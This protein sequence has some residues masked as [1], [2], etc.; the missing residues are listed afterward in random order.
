YMGV[1]ALPAL[2][3]RLEEHG[4]PADWPAAI[5]ERGTR[6]DQ[7]VLT[8]T[9]A[10]LPLQAASAGVGSPALII[11]GEVVRHRVISPA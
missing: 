4:L 11:V 3:A 8:G 7:R 10:S 5:V 1:S 6:A 2:C 9:L